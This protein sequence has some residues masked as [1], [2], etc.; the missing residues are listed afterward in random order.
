M[1][2]KYAVKFV[3][4]SGTKSWC[5]FFGL[6]KQ[7]CLDVSML[8]CTSREDVNWSVYNDTYNLKGECKN[9]KDLPTLSQREHRSLMQYSFFFADL[10]QNL[11]NKKSWYQLRMHSKIYFVSFHFQLCHISVH[12]KPADIFVACLVLV[13]LRMLNQNDVNRLYDERLCLSDSDIISLPT[14]E[15]KTYFS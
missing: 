13:C 2:N 6:Y 12:H 4:R 7:H 3:L 11:F 14:F 10:A 9:T 15:E 5:Q 1:L 8:I